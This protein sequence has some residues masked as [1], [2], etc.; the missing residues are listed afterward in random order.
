[1]D[2]E[3]QCSLLLERLLIYDGSPK[4]RWPEKRLPPKIFKEEFVK[5]RKVPWSLI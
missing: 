3:S 5:R 2:R 4:K 1:M